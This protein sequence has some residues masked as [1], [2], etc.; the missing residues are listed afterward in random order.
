MGRGPGQGA[1]KKM[2][3]GRFLEC[4][5]DHNKGAIYVCVGWE[6]GSLMFGEWLKNLL[7]SAKET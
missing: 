3:T 1:G 7:E 6:G 2:G 5:L 4:S